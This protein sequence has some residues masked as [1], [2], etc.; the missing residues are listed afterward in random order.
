M[1]KISTSIS[2]PRF[3]GDIMNKVK[4]PDTSQPVKLWFS[5]YSWGN[6]DE[7]YVI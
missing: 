1:I 2:H 5:N 6:Q 7:G 3:H 4:S